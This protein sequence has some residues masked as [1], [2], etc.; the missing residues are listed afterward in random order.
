MTIKP[1]LLVVSA[2]PALR[3]VVEELKWR[4]DY[5][6]Q[7]A[8]HPYEAE[9][10]LQNGRVD[11]LLCEAS[12]AHGSE[13][14]LVREICQRSVHLPVFVFVTEENEDYL[15]EA[16]GRATFHVVRPEMPVSHLHER[17]H[18]AVEKGRKLKAA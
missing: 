14:R 12:P 16:R 15:M 11:A 13:C 10:V 1:S 2:G 17:I 18:A 7:Y 4:Y 3:W 8:A 5:N 6:V 9:S